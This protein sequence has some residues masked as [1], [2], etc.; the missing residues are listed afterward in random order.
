MHVNILDPY[1]TN[2]NPP[3][4]A[5]CGGPISA[6]MGEFCEDCLPPTECA[7]CGEPIPAGSEICESCLYDPPP[8]YCDGTM[9]CG[10]CG[11]SRD[12]F[13]RW[14]DPGLFSR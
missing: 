14:A 8:C 4:C 13:A 7:Y 11:S 12:G 9:G 5:S 1:Y 10:L 6:G 2:V 3:E